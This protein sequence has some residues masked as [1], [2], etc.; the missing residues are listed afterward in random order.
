[1][2]NLK[3]YWAGIWLSPIFML[4]YA[5]AVDW[6]VFTKPKWK[7]VARQADKK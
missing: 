1:M 7:K 4:F 3:G 6:G 2:K 5:I